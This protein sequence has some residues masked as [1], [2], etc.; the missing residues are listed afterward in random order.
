MDK[1]RFKTAEIQKIQIARRQLGLSEE[2]YRDIIREASGGKTES[3]TKLTWQG[4]RD[5]LER[6]KEL[7]FIAK[8]AKKASSPAKVRSGKVEVNSRRQADDPQSK[9]LR[10]LWIQLHQEGKVKDSSEA[11]LCSFVKRMTGVDALDWLSD[12][13]VTVCKKALKDWLER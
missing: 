7:G 13:Q 4:R 2:I 6:M 8:P 11:A 5:V 3:S 10:A 1:N 9:M 12:R